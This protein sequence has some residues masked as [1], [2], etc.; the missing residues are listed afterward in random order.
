MGR[1]TGAEHAVPRGLAA[2]AVPGP[3]RS[4][5]PGAIVGSS[6]ASS[7]QLWPLLFYA[8]ERCA[9]TRRC[10][11]SA[12]R[13]KTLRV[14]PHSSARALPAGVPTLGT[15]GPAGSRVPDLDDPSRQ[16]PAF[17][18]EEEEEEEM[19][20]ASG[21]PEDGDAPPDAVGARAPEPTDLTMGLRP[22]GRP[23][24]QACVRLQAGRLIAAASVRARL[25]HATEVTVFW[26]H[27]SSTGQLSRIPAPEHLP[28]PHPC[29]PSP[30]SCRPPPA[31]GGRN[32]CRGF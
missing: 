12:P 15:Q 24:P 32:D 16:H 28:A 25:G 19:E 7:H 3:L 26:Q 17:G 31:S 30:P 22:A 10:H 27:S 9:S 4:G 1:N 8:A 20:G 11:T 23:A 6:A 21:Y 14:W 18:G 5:G 2:D 29:S 13:S